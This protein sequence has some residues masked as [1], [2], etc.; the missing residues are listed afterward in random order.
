MKSYIKISDKHIIILYILMIIFSFFSFFNFNFY[1]QNLSG[2]ILSVAYLFEKYPYFYSRTNK[3][4]SNNTFNLED[5]N[6]FEYFILKSLIS[7]YSLKIN[8]SKYEKYKV[9]DLII[10]GIIYSKEVEQIFNSY[11]FLIYFEDTISVYSLN[12]D[13]YKIE[14]FKKS[15]DKNIGLLMY[16]YAYYLLKQYFPHAKIYA[17]KED[18]LKDLLENKIIY[19][20]LDDKFFEIPQIYKEKIKSLGIIYEEHIGILINKSK[21]ELKDKIF[22]IIADLN[23]KEIFQWLK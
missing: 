21:I 12:S 3:D 18:L 20:V 17:Y 11:F 22:Q 16:S 6:G 9:Y 8:I 7:K 23:F 5:F 14:T 4:V 13:Q 2:K 1:H 19:V 15:D 10:G